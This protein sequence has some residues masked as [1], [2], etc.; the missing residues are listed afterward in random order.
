M[1]PLGPGTSEKRRRAVAGPRWPWLMAVL[2]A[3][4]A[5]CDRELRACFCLDRDV[6]PAR[7]LDSAAFLASLRP[8]RT[9][10]RGPEGEDLRARDAR[11]RRTY[12]AKLRA[13]GVCTRCRRPAAHYLCDGCR[14]SN[15]TYGAA[16][17]DQCVEMGRCQRCPDP[18][19]LGKTMCRTCAGLAAERARAWRA[20]R[21]SVRASA[22]A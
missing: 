8:R 7:P 9:Y 15:E 19:E 6:P 10:Q 11:Y 4:C 12:R 16:W 18:A 22:G 5:W 14:A 1:I 17:R 3:K 13:R 2:D 21:R 20:E